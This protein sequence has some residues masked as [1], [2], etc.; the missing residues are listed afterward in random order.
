MDTKDLSKSIIPK[1]KD[2][3]DPFVKIWGL[4]L[5]LLESYQKIENLP[6]WPVNL[7]IKSHQELI[8]DFIA[9]VVEELAESYEAY[10][11]GD[12][13]NTREELADALHFFMEILI[14]TVPSSNFK[15]VLEI[16][17]NQDTFD[18][19]LHRDQPRVNGLVQWYWYV[20]YHL[21]IA[22]NNLRNKRWKQTQVLA[23][24]AEFIVNL[25]KAFHTLIFGFKLMGMDSTDIYEIYYLKNRVNHFRIKS[26]YVV[27]ILFVIG[28]LWAGLNL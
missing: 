9:R 28:T 20:T 8:K 14:Y 12:W 6:L 3:E 4:Q 15:Q 17:P 13:A 25:A 27:N 2:N 1:L 7:D 10:L 22:R 24:K 5:E 23:Q 16:A 21:N 19:L 18:V 26:R 11:N